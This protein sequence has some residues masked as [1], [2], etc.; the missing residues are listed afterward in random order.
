MTIFPINSLITQIIF[1]FNSPKK[2]NPTIYLGVYTFICVIYCGLM[3]AGLIWFNNV[4]PD[5]VV[6]ALL[7]DVLTVESFKNNIIGPQHIFDHGVEKSHL[8]MRDTLTSL[9]S[10]LRLT[11][12]EKS[13][14][15]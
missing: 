8:I 6:S 11:V 10:P 15:I 13:P 1:K 9:I 3:T 7:S 12:P 2:V 4:N 14:D 5:L